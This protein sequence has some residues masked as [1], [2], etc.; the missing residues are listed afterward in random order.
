MVAT[1][2]FGSVSGS[3]LAFA[4][5]VTVEETLEVEANL[6][7]EEALP[8]QVAEIELEAARTLNTEEPTAAAQVET[9]PLEVAP[10]K[11]VDSSVG[12]ITSVGNR[13][14]TT[15]TSIILPNADKAIARALSVVGSAGL[16]CEDQQCYRL[17]DYLAG[18]I[19]GYSSSGY[20]SAA[21]H[22]QAALNTGVAHPGDRNPP[23]GA[24]LFF[25]GDSEFGHIAIYVGNGMVVS[26]WS[27]GPKG[28]N[29]YLMAADRFGDYLGWA[30][31]VFHGGA[32]GSAL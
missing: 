6:E 9:Q 20:M 3:N 15:N 4:D 2:L 5:E 12:Y 26:N 18:W 24:A 16:A 10:A 27:G 23:L 14:V 32:V 8:V 21:T 22:W 31:P 7:R 13:G 1:S 19:W 30:M 29:V 17:C 11:P 28:S 25:K